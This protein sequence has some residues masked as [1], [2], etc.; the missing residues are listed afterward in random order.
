VSAPP[1]TASLY[2]RIG[3]EPALAAF[4][5][6]FYEVMASDPEVQRI[7]LLHPPDIADLK[8]RLVA[9]LSGFVGGPQ[10]YPQRYGPPFMRARHLHVPIGSEERDMWLKCASA[11]LGTAIADP[12]A[13]A[14]FGA[15][16]DAFADHM[17]NVTSGE[18]QVGAIGRPRS[19]SRRP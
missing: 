19:T 8:E 7:W 12:Q 9:F 5:E 17:R 11:A 13:R 18:E 10:V 14:E 15:K 1:E 16:L 6:H 4:V 2:D 3:G